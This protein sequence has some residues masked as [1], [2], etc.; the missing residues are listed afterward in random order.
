MTVSHTS[1]VGRKPILIE[2]RSEPD[3]DRI[4]TRN[5]QKTTAGSVRGRFTRESEWSEGVTKKKV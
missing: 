2:G 1:L 3:S 5:K 4:V